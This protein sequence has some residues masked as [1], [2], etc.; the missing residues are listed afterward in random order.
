VK[1]WAI[2]TVVVLVAVGVVASA[3]AAIHASTF[4]SG[5]ANCGVT[6][7][8][9]EMGCF[10]PVLPANSLDGFIQLGAHGHTRLSERGDCPFRQQCKAGP[11][12]R[13]G[14]D[15]KRVGVKC[16][17]GRGLRCENKDDHGFVLRRHSY[18]RF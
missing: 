4:S 15:W 14:Q 18:R 5:D 11:K 6:I 1:A 17:H 16:H 12:L 3:R 13:R 10:S 9:R 2:F 7:G 8:K